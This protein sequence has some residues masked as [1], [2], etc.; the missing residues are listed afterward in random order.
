VYAEYP[1]LNIGNWCLFG[2]SIVRLG[3]NKNFS[4]L[5]SGFGD[6]TN[7]RIDAGDGDLKYKLIFERNPKV[8]ENFGFK[9][10]RVNLLLEKIKNRHDDFGGQFCEREQNFDFS[11]IDKTAMN[12]KINNFSGLNHLSGDKSLS[13]ELLEKATDCVHKVVS[14]CNGKM[15]FVGLNSLILIIDIVDVEKICNEIQRVIDKY[16]NKKRIWNFFSYKIRN[17]DHSIRFKDLKSKKEYPDG[18]SISNINVKP[19]SKIKNFGDLLD[20]KIESFMKGV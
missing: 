16:I 14:K 20:F 10:P 18:I 8:I 9:S 2:F 6:K 3:K 17:I 1:A 5:Y 15:Y 7:V 11:Q 19:M 4:D 12:I 13:Y